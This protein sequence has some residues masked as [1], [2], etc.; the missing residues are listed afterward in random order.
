MR[1]RSNRPR[2]RPPGWFRWAVLGGMLLAVALPAACVLGH[3]ELPGYGTF[4]SLGH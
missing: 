3:G 1:I 2:R 4:P